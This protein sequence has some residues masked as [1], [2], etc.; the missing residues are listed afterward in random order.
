MFGWGVAQAVTQHARQ[1]SNLNF[2]GS[3]FNSAA[4]L[5]LAEI[6]SRYGFNPNELESL[7]VRTALGWQRSANMSLWAGYQWNYLNNSSGFIQANRLW[8]QLLWNILKTDSLTLVSQ[9]RLEERTQKDQRQWNIRFR[10]L[11]SLELANPLSKRWR[12]FIWDEVF[13][14]LTKPSWVANVTVEQNRAFAG[15][16]W[17]PNKSGFVQVGYLNQYF[18]RPNFDQMNHVFYLG[19][20]IAT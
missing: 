11:L 18:F 4:G 7:H 2:Q 1:W 19:I 16:K 6:Q 13:F 10:Q 9:S 20:F 8:Q 17:I 14:N 3:L 12:P 5:Y 15:A